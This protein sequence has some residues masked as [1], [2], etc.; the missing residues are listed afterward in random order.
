MGNSWARSKD[1]VKAANAQRALPSKHQDDQGVDEDSNTEGPNFRAPTIPALAFALRETE[2]ARQRGLPVLPGES[3]STSVSSDCSSDEQNDLL[4]CGSCGIEPTIDRPLL[5]C[6]KCN[7][8]RYCS[9]ECQKAHWSR[10][11]KCCQA[12]ASARDD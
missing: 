4:N 7:E 6:G 2:R 12:L 5:L 10:H 3:T 11:K 8:Q 9:R 1:A